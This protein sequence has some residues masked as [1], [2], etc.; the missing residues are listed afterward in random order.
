MQHY[1]A[2]VVGA[3]HNALVTAAYLARSGKKVLVLERRSVIGGIAATE[4]IFPEFKCSTGAHLAGT[5]SREIIAE[6]ELQKHGLKL[7][8]PD[9][10]IFAHKQLHINPVVGAQESARNLLG[11]DFNRLQPHALGNLANR[12]GNL[13]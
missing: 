4:E 13:T 2:I 8:S 7:L 6:L 10:L 12:V 11:I 9:P 3:G 1:D 5:F